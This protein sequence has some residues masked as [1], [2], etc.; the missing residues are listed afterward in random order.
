MKCLWKKERWVNASTGKKEELEKT[1]GVD[2][3]GGDGDSGTSLTFRA[4]S[5]ARSKRSLCY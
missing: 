3:N 2:G 1:K 5:S 4:T